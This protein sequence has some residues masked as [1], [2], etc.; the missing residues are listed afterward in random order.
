MVSFIVG[1]VALVR[2][3]LYR[4]V[5]LFKDQKGDTETIEETESVDSNNS[6]DTEDDQ[7]FLSRSM[8]LHRRMSTSQLLKHDSVITWK[9]AKMNVLY[10]ASVCLTYVVTLV[11]LNTLLNFFTIE[12]LFIFGSEHH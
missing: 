10:N 11:R 4:S 9:I 1:T 7:V 12:C 8:E 6:D 5:V 3:A 2:S